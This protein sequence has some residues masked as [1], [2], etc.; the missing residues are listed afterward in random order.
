M[1]ALERRL[2]MAMRRWEDD[3][4]AAL[5]ERYGEARANDLYRIYENAFPASYREEYTVREALADIE[6]LEM[7]DPATDLGMNLHVRPDAQPPGSTS[8]STAAAPAWRF[9]TACRCSS[10]LACV[11]YEHPH[12]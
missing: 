4:Q 7:F 8:R 11:Q 12:E 3:L 9:P 6:M 5:L 10:A 1:K 2:A